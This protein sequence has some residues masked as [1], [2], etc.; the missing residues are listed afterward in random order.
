MEI[1]IGA[2]VRNIVSKQSLLKIYQHQFYITK[3]TFMLQKVLLQS[4]W[5]LVFVNDLHKVTK[6]LDPI[7][8]TDDTNLFYSHEN[9]SGEWHIDFHTHSKKIE[10]LQ[11]KNKDNCILEKLPNLYLTVLLISFIFLFFFLFVDYSKKQN[12]AEKMI[13]LNQKIRLSTT[14]QTNKLHMIIHQQLQ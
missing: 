4:L 14:P 7:I 12:Q 8:F 5:L 11:D 13:Y 3:R 9:I 2:E 10:C 6:Y 1:Q